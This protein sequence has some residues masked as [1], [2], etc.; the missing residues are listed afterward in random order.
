MGW[1]ELEGTKDQALQG[2][3]PHWGLCLYLLA[4]RS[5]VFAHVGFENRLLSY[6]GSLLLPPVISGLKAQL[7]TKWGS[8]GLLCPTLGPRPPLASLSTGVAVVVCDRATLP[9]PPS[10]WSPLPPSCLPSTWPHPY[11]GCPLAGTGLSSSAPGAQQFCFLLSTRAGGLGI[12]LATADT[13][14]IYDSDWNPHN[15]IQVCGP[16]I[17]TFSDPSLPLVPWPFPPLPH[18]PDCVSQGFTSPWA[19][20]ME[21]QPQAGPWEMSGGFALL[22]QLLTVRRRKRAQR[23]QGTASPS[24]HPQD[25]GH[26]GRQDEGVL[27][28]RGGQYERG[29]E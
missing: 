6:S 13:V 5:V 27:E 19:S 4:V 15:D 20:P 14:I 22:L 24:H 3:D 16:D 17:G 21:S 11:L 23:G 28:P 9:T 7:A 18:P 2:A 29:Q 12:N 25:Q 10:L 26:G 8:G 1:G